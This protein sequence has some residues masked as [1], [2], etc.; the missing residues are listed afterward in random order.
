MMARS[1]LPVSPRHIAAFLTVAM[2]LLWPTLLH[3]Q[4]TDP[5]IDPSA[6]GVMSAPG[7]TI[8]RPS[9]LNGWS[10][11]FDAPESTGGFVDGP[12][13]PPRGTGSVQLSISAHGV[14]GGLI[15]AVSHALREQVPGQESRWQAIS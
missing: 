3:A 7:A 13:V 10:F 1:K 2:M 6:P 5:V 11:S 12:A 8:V 4:S 9:A 14:E 15:Y